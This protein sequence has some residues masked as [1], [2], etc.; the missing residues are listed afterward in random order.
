MESSRSGIPLIDRAEIVRHRTALI[1]SEGTFTYSELLDTSARVSSSLLGCKKDLQGAR[2]AFLTPPSF[3]YVAT[4]W[5]VWRAGGIAIPLSLKDTRP[6]LEYVITNS[7]ASIL[8]AHRDFEPIIK[9]IAKDHHIRFE[10][11]TH[12][13]NNDIKMLPR[14]DMNSK[15]T[16]LYTSGTT[17]KPKGVVAT[18]NN[19]EAQVTSL[20]KA[21]EWTKND[22]ILNALP[23]HHVHGIINALTCALWVGATC[24]ILPRFDADQIWSR[25]SDG[26]LTLYMAVPT[27]YKALINKWNSASSAKQKVM[28]KGSSKLRMMVSGSDKLEI[29]TLKE[30]HAITGQIL[31][32]RYGMTEIGMALS[33]PLHGKRVPGCVGNS[34]PGVKVRIVKLDT[35]TISDG[36]KHIH[37]EQ[38]RDETVP[39]EIQVNGPNVFKEYWGM[40]ETT[41][42]S[43]TKDGWFCTGD[44]AIVEDGQYRILGRASQD[45][46]IS[47]GENV[48]L[49]EI[50]EILST[51]P[52]IKECTV[53]AVPDK[54]WGKAVSTAVTLRK[55]TRLTRDGLRDWARDKLANHKLPQK[56]LVQDSLPRTAVG[57]VMKPEIVKLFLEKD[58]VTQ[59]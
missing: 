26:D 43:F 9:S 27:S 39:G 38:I 30:W 19:I 32:E 18:H 3:E 48:N 49:K 50:E 24:E 29:P 36:G 10:S 41:A 28:S 20:V 17:S 55:G 42:S 54:Y 35:E 44:M 25:L 16:I 6:E 22:H 34:L 31:L 5:G 15:A 51:H 40:P 14:L 56:I 11:T 59:N 23:L 47:G 13:I 7:G 33:N 4:L 2:V 37:G 57:K 45:F 46:M 8:I 52:D 21:W 58:N 12:L 53:V 1:S